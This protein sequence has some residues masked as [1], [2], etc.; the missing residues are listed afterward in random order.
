[1]KRLYDTKLAVMKAILAEVDVVNEVGISEAQAMRDM[2]RK[3][4]PFLRTKLE[5]L[6]EMKRG[7]AKAKA[8]SARLRS[9]LKSGSA[10]TSPLRIAS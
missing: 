1:M 8:F 4:L 7:A 5:E 6:K 10:L 9:F 3:D 2:R